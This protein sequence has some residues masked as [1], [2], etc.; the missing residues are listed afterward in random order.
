MRESI[1]LRLFSER[2][3][4]TLMDD[5]DQGTEY[6]CPD[7]TGGKNAQAGYVCQ[8]AAG[9]EPGYN[10]TQ[11]KKEDVRKDRCCSCGKRCENDCAE[12]VICMGGATPNAD[13]GNNPG[14]ESEDCVVPLHGPSGV[15]LRDQGYDIPA[16]VHHNATA[17]EGKPPVDY[18]D[19]PLPEPRQQRT[20]IWRFRA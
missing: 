3:L 9:D 2:D 8:N 7:G 11:E 13:T 1:P 10:T 6:P 20:P 17:K 5:P 18:F 19:P 15:S 16:K 14:E 4:A 12:R